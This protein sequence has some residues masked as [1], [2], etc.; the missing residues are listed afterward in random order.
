VL[1]AR[2][3]SRITHPHVVAISDIGVIDDAPFMVM[4]LLEGDELSTVIDRDG[5]LP[6]DRLAGV[7]LPVI[8]AV[9]AAHEAGILHRDLKPDNVFLS[10]RNPFA[11]APRPGRRRTTLGEHPVL[12]DFG[13]SKLDT[14][15]GAPALTAANEVLGTPPYMAPEQVLR[16]MT[17]FDER[18][19][20]YA[21]GV[22]LYE[23]ATGKQPYRDTAG[24]H[25]LMVEISKGGAPPPSALRPSIP[26]AFDALVMRAMSVD[27]ARRFDSLA[28]LGRA[29]LP[30]A[31]PLARA[32]WTEVLDDGEDEAA[33]AFEPP[34]LLRPLDLGALPLLSGVPEAELR[35]LV[36]LC[37]PAP[38]A[39]GD[40]LFD[41][42]ARAASALLV[43]RGEVELFRTH[44]AETWVLDAVG[45]GA[46]LGLPALWDDA[47]R[48]VSAIARSDG[49]VIEIERDAMAELG[50]A[51]LCASDRLHDHAATALARRLHGASDRFGKLVARAKGGPSAEALAW[52]AA[53][54]GEV[55]LPLPEEG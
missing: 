4:D 9:A 10:R 7:M 24:I 42:G 49:V 52:L 31:G 43:V 54:V 44:G 27:P 45:T 55:A 14:G 48:A 35:A 22:V 28:D 5:A 39:S 13:I 21:L 17:A 37:P 6:L 50:S 3:A 51:C 15:G 30:F 23:C 36:D 25:P 46:L 32:L 20:Q 40:A 19:D 53:S 41:Q 8:S 12:L 26:P 16:G 18:S 29:L 1:E 11:L 2:A 33:P 38:F 34:P 47:R